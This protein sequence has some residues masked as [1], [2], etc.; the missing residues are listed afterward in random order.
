VYRV[1]QVVA[2]PCSGRGGG[3]GG[4]AGEPRAAFAKAYVWCV[5]MFCK[6]RENVAGGGGLGAH[7][8]AENERRRPVARPAEVPA[9]YGAQA[10]KGRGKALLQRGE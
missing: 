7:P 2:L 8:V 1:G 5:C 3:E 10:E 6:V 9:C 4:S